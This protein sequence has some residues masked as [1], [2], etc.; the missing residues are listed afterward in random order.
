MK[1]MDKT[2]SAIQSASLTRRQVLAATAAAPIALMSGPQ[3][4]QAADPKPNILYIMADD[5]GYAD[6]SCFGRREYTTTNIDKLAAGGAK[7]LQAY[8]NS[9]VCSATRTALI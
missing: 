8:A 7:L 4:A 1:A 3:L 6:V 2:S 9:A 5:M